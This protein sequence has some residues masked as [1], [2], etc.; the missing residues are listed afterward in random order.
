V[1]AVVRFRGWVRGSAGP[2]EE[3]GQVVALLAVGLVA[4]L[5]L[6]ALAIDVGSWYY[7]QRRLQA[8]ADAAAL[9]GVQVLPLDSVGATTLATQYMGKNDPTVTASQISLGATVEPNDTIDVKLAHPAPGFFSQVFGISSVTVHAAAAAESF[10]IGQALYVAPITVS[11]DQPQLAG[12][13]CPCFNQPTSLPLGKNG[14]PGSFGLINL[15]GSRGG[16][17]GPNTLA[18]WLLNGYP[19]YLGLGGYYSNP[20]AKFNA[21]QMQSALNARIGTTMLF[22]V[23]DSLSGNGANAQYNVIGW[24]GFYMTGFDARGSSGTLYGHFTS[25]TWDGIN[26]SVGS[27]QP[28]FGARVVRL[29]Q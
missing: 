24:V 12:S 29:I 13:G 27:Q 20:G 7:A 22:P 3:R 4:F 5:G 26:A 2:V 1:A 9:A 6:S 28:D 25:I 11:K 21:A 10:P 19:G 15:D 17:G 18:D 14:A 16:N 8:T 23:F